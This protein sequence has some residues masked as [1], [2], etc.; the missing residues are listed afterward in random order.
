MNQLVAQGKFNWN[1]HFCT[2]NLLRKGKGKEKEN[3]NEKDNISQEKGH[4]NQDMIE[5]EVLMKAAP[6]GQ[7]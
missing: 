7:K 2:K 3:D 4:D 5:E 6:K 1:L